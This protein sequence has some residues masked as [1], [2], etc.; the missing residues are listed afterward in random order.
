MAVREILEMEGYA[1]L[2]AT[3]GLQGL[4]VMEEARPDIIVAD[5]MMPKMD[6]YAFY[7]AVRARPEWVLIPFIFLTA[8][9]DKR[10]VLKGRELGAEDY[11]TKPF[12]P[13]ELIVAVRARLT[14]AEVVR[15]ASGAEF[16]RLKQQIVTLLSH[17][18]RTPVNYVVGYTDLAREG[19]E[20]ASPEELEIFL[21]GIKAGAGRLSGLVEDLLFAVR[22]D[23]GRAEQE[24][25]MLARIH[26]NLGE[27]VEATLLARK[28][29]AGEFGVALEMEIAPHLPPVQLCRP[30]FEEALGRVV[31]NAI[32]FSRHKGQRVTVHVQAVESRVEIAV[33][34]EGVGISAA[35]IPHLFERFRQ[36]DRERMEQQ[37]IGMGLAIARDLVRLHGGDIIVESGLGRGSTF[38]IWIPVA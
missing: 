21:N 37:G 28:A 13:Q 22:L 3:D 14:R 25:Q 12:D 11:L 31:D 24:Y 15:Q 38:T 2:T 17:E 9:T 1:V 16:D 33:T 23:T 26:R 34:D 7:Q 4:E 5:V 18:L 30:F 32:K 27:I 8:K 36:F 10:D 19:L 6:G 20:S 35:N 29:Q